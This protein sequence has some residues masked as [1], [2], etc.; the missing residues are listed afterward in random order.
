MRERNEESCDSPEILQASL[1]PES[2]LGPEQP[3]PMGLGSE[4]QAFNR[5]LL[6]SFLQMQNLLGDWF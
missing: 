6:F 2:G 5:H 3:E 4:G 1:S